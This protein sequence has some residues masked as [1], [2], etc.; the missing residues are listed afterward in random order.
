MQVKSGWKKYRNEILGIEFI[1]P[2]KWG[3]I[4]LSPSNNITD[5]KTI[6]QDFLDTDDDFRYMVK[7]KFRENYEISVDFINNE[8]PGEKY[9]NGLAYKYG[10]MDNFSKLIDTQDICRYHFSFSNVIDGSNV[11]YLEKHNKCKDGIKTTLFLN[12][13]GALKSFNGRYYTYRIEQYFYKRLNN[14]YFNNLLIKNHIASYQGGESDLDFNQIFAKDK[15]GNTSTILD[16]QEFV[17]SVKVFSPPIPTTISFQENKNEDLGVTTIRKY[18]YL[19]ATQKLSEAFNMHQSPNFSFVDFTNWYRQVFNAKVY[20]IKSNSSYIYKFNVDLSERNKPISKYLIT[21][22]INGDKINTLSSEQIL[23]DEIKF[24]DYIAYTRL[25][26]NKNEIV[27]IKNGVEKVLNGGDNDFLNKTETSVSFD[28]PKFSPQGGYLIYNT[29][30]WEWSSPTLYDL[31]KQQEVEIDLSYADDIF[32]SQDEKYLLSCT[33]AGIA[34]GVSAI[35]YSAP[36]FIVKKDF[37]NIIENLT[38]EPN[39]AECSYSP[40]KS[41]YTII[42]TNNYGQQKTIRYNLVTEKEITQ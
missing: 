18:Y 39:I 36:D 30:A 14:N 17:S 21:V 35:V 32:F 20:N 5:L 40:E 6:N 34:S 37:K 23:S 19:L 16:F 9:P 25:R 7:L 29:S 26:S 11:T 27:L 33:S 28:N 31:T 42:V 41:E 22:K 15:D 13:P 3:E 2:E 12:D 4:S 10:P 38:F 24:G 1:Y 8:Y